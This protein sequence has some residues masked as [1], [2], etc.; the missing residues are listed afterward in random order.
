MSLA[1]ARGVS[2]SEVVGL[3][4]GR[5]VPA[6][7][8]AGA[9]GAAEVTLNRLREPA[10]V[11]AGDAA[12]GDVVVMPGSVL[13]QLG[14]AS[15]AGAT[16]PGLLV[17]PERS[18]PVDALPCA[19]LVVADARLAFAQ[20]SAL[21][22]RTP[23]PPPGQHASAVVAPDASVAPDAALA[24]GVVVGAGAVIGAGCAI[25]PNSVV[26]AGARLGE[27]CRLHANVT[28]YPGVSL[29]HR[30]ELH[31]GC[32]VGGDGFGYAAGPVGA[33]KIH[34]GGSVVIAD[35]VEVGANT[36]IDRG[37]LGDTRIGARTKVDGMCMIAHNVQIGNDCLIAG[38]T[39]IAGSTTIGDGV[40]IGG[41]ASITDHVTVGTG[42]RI[43]GRAA[44]TKNVPAGEAWTGNPAKPHRQYARDL[45]LRG[46]LEQ[47]WQHFR[48]L[49]GDAGEDASADAG[50]LEEARGEG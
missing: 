21:F 17:V 1:P 2:V 14:D 6:A 32:V 4:G 19:V 3:V 22:Y 35:D 25:G 27:H 45:Y 11:L 44:V 30:V 18:A 24:A 20:L 9:S 46:R 33:V 47:I 36:C 29:G 39:G 43:G 48:P 7:A 12:A 5:L 42:A 31:A 28:L 13:D 8:A 34:H 41:A 23:V 15:A 16:W 26:G 37:T 40:I 38:Q 50:P 10:A 49:A